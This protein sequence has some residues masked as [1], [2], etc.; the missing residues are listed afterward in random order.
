MVRAPVRFRLNNERTTDPKKKMG[1][2]RKKKGQRSALESLP[3]E[4]ALFVSACLD[5][6]SHGR[7]ALCQKDSKP[8]RKEVACNPETQRGSFGVVEIRRFTVEKE[9]EDEEVWEHDHNYRCE[10][11]GYG[12][13]IIC[14]DYCNVVYH[15]RCLAP[16]LSRPPLG[17]WRC[18]ACAEESRAPVI[19]NVSAFFGATGGLAAIGGFKD[20]SFVANRDLYEVSPD[21]MWRKAKTKNMPATDFCGHSTVF[22][23]SKL[24]VFGR[25]G[26][27]PTPDDSARSRALASATRFDRVFQLHEKIWKRIEIRENAPSPRVDAALCDD[28]DRIIL[29]GGYCPE[30]RARLRGLYALDKMSQI[31]HCITPDT[32]IEE[33]AP[34]VIEAAA[35]VVIEAPVVVIEAPAPEQRERSP[36]V[37]LNLRR[38]VTASRRFDDE[39]WKQSSSLRTKKSRRKVQ[40]VGPGPRSGHSLTKVGDIVLFGGLTD[41]GHASD[42]WRLE[43]TTFTA[44]KCSGTS[45]RARAAH[46]AAAVG[47]HLIIFGGVTSQSFLNDFFV[48]D[49]VTQLWS[50]PSIDGPVPNPRMRASILLV[51]DDRPCHLKRQD[52]HL[53]LFGGSRLW[54][55]DAY[56]PMTTETLDG[57]LFKINLKV[58]PPPAQEDEEKV[59]PRRRRRGRPAAAT[60]LTASS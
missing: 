41:R 28:K 49:T 55:I 15:G 54:G 52:A 50:S 56:Q 60:N 42:V 32:I 3:L 2:T 51:P 10:A 31:W 26:P 9:D 46:S 14:C 36:W 43:G 38:S 7:W 4:L 34:L 5:V 25:R 27:R 53:L 18:P 44:L 11:C 24:W 1:K 21:N 48:L 6:K 16:P 30:R 40:T 29:Y 35:P 33:T 8:P 23:G 57:D 13:E 45:P 39:D 58:A 17:R 59:V 19:G 12:G 22:D 20:S 47:P 37:S